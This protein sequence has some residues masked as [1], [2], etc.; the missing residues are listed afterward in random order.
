[1]RFYL[2]CHQPA[3]L[4]A[5]DIPLFISHRRLAHR[6]TLPRALGPWCLDSGAFSEI[7][8][9]GRW[10]I[11]AEQYAAAVRRYVQEIGGLQWAA[12]MDWMCEP[13]VIGG[14]QVGRSRFVGT[15]L[16]VEAHQQLTVDNYLR[17]RDIAPDLPIVPV[18]QGWQRDDYLRCVDLFARSGVDLEHEPV[19][20][21]GS[22]CRRQG[23]GEIR[24]IVES[25][26]ALRIRLHGFGVKTAGL[27][28]YGRH[29]ASAD[30]LAWSYQGRYRPGCRV[31]HRTEANCARWAAEWRQKIIRTSETGLPRDSS[32]RRRR[33]CGTGGSR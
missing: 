1:M 6:R 31:G 7:Q 15:G 28:I 24:A 11:T 30:S 20:G 5:T 10:T 13:V 3:W 2:G 27:G 14:G 23:T 12:Q 29:L 17:L 19:V 4:A 26:A 33:R 32:A 18:I 22:V 25:V 9:Y 21:L 16:S 8:Q